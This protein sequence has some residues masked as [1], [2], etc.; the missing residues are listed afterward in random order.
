MVISIENFITNIKH[1]T[2]IMDTAKTNQRGEI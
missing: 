2:N 1:T